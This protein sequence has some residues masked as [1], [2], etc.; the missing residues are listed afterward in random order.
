[1]NRGFLVRIVAAAVLGLMAMPASAQQ[2]SEASQFM[3]A[4]KERDAEK[5]IALISSPGSTVL[6]SRNPDSGD[7]AL[8]LLV[9]ERDVTWIGYLLN[10]GARA[11]L[12]NRDGMT[13]L[14][15][16]AQI[17]WIEGAE[18]LLRGGAKVD[19]PNRQGETPLILAVHN[20][21]IG[22][23]RLLL[24]R[25]ADPNRGDTVSGHSALD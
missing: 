5:A 13:P 23:V 12:Q 20:R 9:R 11:D 10:K 25:G 3:K 18:R 8:H 1:V 17:G 4:V 2:I 22:M 24:S 7:G 15:L 6:N 21:D 16:A 14:A 19:F